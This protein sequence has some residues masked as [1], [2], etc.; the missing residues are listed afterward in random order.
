[1]RASTSPSVSLTSKPDMRTT[2]IA[3]AP[4]AKPSAATLPTGVSTIRLL[5]R[6]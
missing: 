5:A 4:S 3:S 6:A 1:M 2:T